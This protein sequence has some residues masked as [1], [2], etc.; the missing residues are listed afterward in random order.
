MTVL[1]AVLLAYAVW[2]LTVTAMRVAGKRTLN[3]ARKRGLRIGYSGVVWAIRWGS[4]VCPCHTCV[5]EPAPCSLVTG[6]MVGLGLCITSL[7]TV[8]YTLY[9]T[10]LSLGGK[11]EVSPYTLSLPQASLGI[12]IPL[13]LFSSILHE[14]GHA[15]MMKITKTPLIGVDLGVYFLW[16]GISVIGGSC[17]EPRST[18]ARRKHLER[19]IWNVLGG[20]LGNIG[21]ALL[22]F[23]LAYLVSGIA[24]SI[25]PHTPGVILPG[26]E[27]E[28]IVELFGRP[29]LNKKEYAA[30]LRRLE[31]EYTK[32]HILPSVYLK[33]SFPTHI[34]AGPSLEADYHEAQVEAYS[35]KAQRNGISNRHESTDL[36]DV[37]VLGGI[38]VPLRQ[39]EDLGISSQ[40]ESDAPTRR[41]ILISRRVTSGGKQLILYAPYSIESYAYAGLLSLARATCNHSTPDYVC[42]HPRT[43]ES[44]PLVPVFVP[45]RTL[46]G[47]VHMVEIPLLAGHATPLRSSS[48]LAALQK[49]REA[50][51][52]ERARTAA[53]A[54]TLIHFFQLCVEVSLGC[55]IGAFLG[56]PWFS[57]GQVFLSSCLSKKPTLALFIRSLYF[58]VSTLLC[59]V[60]IICA[61]L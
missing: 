15:I 10:L 24:Q 2:A 43:T 16:P 6:I 35:P 39:Y 17:A 36:D 14:I 8:G 11:D 45:A 5:R 57:D 7:F 28:T 22:C 29:T 25:I 1:V 31:L 54:N 51:E 52:R 32:T 27:D 9:R 55:A 41:P 59:L 26:L 33:R 48:R 37:H 34:V 58:V 18:S 12:I 60:L 20:G 4:D 40:S 3:L 38:Q 47:R 21:V 23:S 30:T 44:N 42:I 46:S 50:G 19:S 53:V 49:V 13:F 61:V 56:F